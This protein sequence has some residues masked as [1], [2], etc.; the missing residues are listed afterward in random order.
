MVS[1]GKRNAESEKVPIYML[2]SFRIV[3]KCF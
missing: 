3:M 2:E 1:R